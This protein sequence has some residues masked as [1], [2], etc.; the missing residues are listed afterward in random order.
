MKANYA[1]QGF[2]IVA[3]NLDKDRKLADKFLKAVDVNFKIAFDESGKTA[4]SYKLRGMPSSYL[5]DRDGKVHA[6]HVG[7]R[8]K[9]KSELEQAIKSLLNK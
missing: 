2:E 3:V 8:D 5:I 6:S 7:F 1:D 9:D 4:S